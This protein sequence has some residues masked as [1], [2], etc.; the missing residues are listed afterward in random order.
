M[1]NILCI[2]FQIFLSLHIW[3]LPRWDDGVWQRPMIT[4]SWVLVSQENTCREDEARQHNYTETFALSP[5]MPWWAG[6]LLSRLHEPQVV[7]TR[8][9]WETLWPFPCATTTA[10]CL[11][12]YYFN[13]E[14]YVFGDSRKTQTGVGQPHHPGLS[15]EEMGTPLALLQQQPGGTQRIPT[16]ESKRENMHVGKNGIMSFN[17]SHLFLVSFI[18][19]M[20]EWPLLAY[21]PLEISP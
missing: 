12:S 6:G 15:R 21:Y 10:E 5:M 18:V 13:G 11:V 1:S 9:G 2:S 4:N 20:V 8:E 19:T 3:V 17:S 16:T 14:E 7:D